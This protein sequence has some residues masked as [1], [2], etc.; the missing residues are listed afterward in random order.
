MGLMLNM[1][2]PLKKSSSIL[3]WKNTRGFT[4]TH[5]SNKRTYS[6]LIGI[7][8]NFRF[9]SYTYIRIDFLS[10]KHEQVQCTKIEINSRRSEFWTNHVETRLRRGIR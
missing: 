5:R 10:V 7:I 9:F 4:D 3:E 6:F 2:N 1:L 8:P